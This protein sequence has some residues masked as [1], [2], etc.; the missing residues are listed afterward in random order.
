[1]TGLLTYDAGFVS[2]FI[3]LFIQEENDLIGWYD[4]DQTEGNGA[5]GKGIHEAIARFFFGKHFADWAELEAHQLGIL[6]AEYIWLLY[7]QQFDNAAPRSMKDETAKGL[8]KDANPYFLGT[9][10]FGYH[11]SAVQPQ[12]VEKVE[13]A[14]DQ[15]RD[16]SVLVPWLDPEPYSFPADLKLTQ[17]WYRCTC[18]ECGKKQALFSKHGYDLFCA[19]TEGYCYYKQS[20]FDLIMEHKQ[21][22]VEQTIEY[23]QS[24]A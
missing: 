15:N 19:Y 23:I 24:F 9:F 2:V 4:H 22:S 3:D 18:P 21:F 7:K 13:A 5:V 16:R 20:L 14:L 12:E 10:D 17:E 6:K 11:Y 1:M 8:L